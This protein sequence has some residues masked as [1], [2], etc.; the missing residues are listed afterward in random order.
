MTWNFAHHMGYHSSSP[1][2]GHRRRSG[3]GLGAGEDAKPRFSHLRTACRSSAT[4]EPPQRDRAHGLPQ[5]DHQQRRR[6]GAHE[7]RDAARMDATPRATQPSPPVPRHHRGYVSCIYVT[8]CLHGNQLLVY[9]C[10]CN[11]AN[12]V[13][14]DVCCTQCM[15]CSQLHSCW[16][17]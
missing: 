16:I 1:G 10:L 15:F 17:C 7:G 14:C 2:R 3:A 8:E 13:M 12:A 5:G 6:I 9:V 4:C 11:V